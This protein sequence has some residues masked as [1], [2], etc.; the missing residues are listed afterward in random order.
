M[1]PCT[2]AALPALGTLLF[3]INLGTPAW[4]LS[5]VSFGSLSCTVYTGAWGAVSQGC[6]AI[7]DTQDGFNSHQ[8]GGTDI[9]IWQAGATLAF[10]FGLCS[11]VFRQRAHQPDVPDRGL[12]RASMFCA[13][14]AIIG[15]LASIMQV[16]DLVKKASSGDIDADTIGLNYFVCF[17]LQVVGLLLFA[18]SAS[19]DF[20]TMSHS[21]TWASGQEQLNPKEVNDVCSYNT[22]MRKS[23]ILDP[24][25]FVPPKEVIT[26]KSGAANPA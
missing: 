22:K 2:T 9:Q 6:E 21:N 5:Q 7:T 13:A 15:G 11:F 8:H 19:I 23:V 16:V 14:I 4:V 10:V 12:L 25:T 18:A 17:G 20:A 26:R 24:T 1:P 3:L